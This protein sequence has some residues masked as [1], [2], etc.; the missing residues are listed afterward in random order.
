M[1]TMKISGQYLGPFSN[2]GER[3]LHVH[4]RAGKG[5][6]V[7]NLILVSSKIV[8]T[9]ADTEC[10]TRQVGLIGFFD[11]HREK[12]NTPAL[13]LGVGPR[14]RHT[15]DRPLVNTLRVQGLPYPPTRPWGMAKAGV[16]YCHSPLSRRTC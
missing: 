3:M 6:A 7:N 1:L 2:A 13:P 11:A 5:F 16:L 15:V 4:C 14:V 9:F 10:N 8:S 12:F